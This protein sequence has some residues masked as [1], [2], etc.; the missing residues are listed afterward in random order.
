MPAINLSLCPYL[1][2]CNYFKLV[3][4]ISLA[5]AWLDR[6]CKSFALH[7]WASYLQMNLIYQSACTCGHSHNLQHY[8]TF[9][10]RAIKQ[11]HFSIDWCECHGPC[12]LS[13][14]WNYSLVYTSW[15]KKTVHKSP[16]CINRDMLFPHSLQWLVC[17]FQ[18]NVLIQIILYI[19]L[20]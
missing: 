6:A 9:I 16:F 7:L 10:D 13:L 4:H 8:A 3:T 15:D 18:L 20:T 1:L 14:Y 5:H 19:S 12:L 17:L 11:E 2:C